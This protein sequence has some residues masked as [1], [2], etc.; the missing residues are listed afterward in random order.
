MAYS[1]TVLDPESLYRIIFMKY[2]TY[3]IYLVYYRKGLDYRTSCEVPKIDLPRSVVE[4][5]KI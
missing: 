5:A 4:V 3:L 2:I 1:M